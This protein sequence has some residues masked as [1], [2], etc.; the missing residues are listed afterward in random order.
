MLKGDLTPF[1]R[2]LYDAEAD[3]ERSGSP[4]QAVHDG[5]AQ[6]HRIVQLPDLRGSRPRTPLNRD[7]SY[8][9]VVVH[10]QTARGI[11]DVAAFT[12]HYED[13]KVVAYPDVSLVAPMGL[14]DL[15]ANSPGLLRLRLPFIPLAGSNG[16]ANLCSLLHGSLWGRLRPRHQFVGHEVPVSIMHEC[17]GC[18]VLKFD[19]GRVVTGHGSL[20]QP[21][22]D[23]ATDASDE[24]ITQHP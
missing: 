14:F 22:A 24:S 23:H 16:L 9:L 15:A 1:F 4:R 2:G 20:W 6:H 19:V 17:G 18:P 11:A 8:Y 7:F 21:L 3:L 13:P 5:F 10:V 12:A